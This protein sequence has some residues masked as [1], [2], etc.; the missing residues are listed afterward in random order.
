MEKFL[1]GVSCQL[2]CQQVFPRGLKKSEI[3]KSVLVR[4]FKIRNCNRV[5]VCVDI[6]WNDQTVFITQ[7]FRL[8]AK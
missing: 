7:S 3:S 8:V 6:T 4:G 1:K 5:G 2:E